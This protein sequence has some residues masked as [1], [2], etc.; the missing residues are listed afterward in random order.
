MATPSKVGPS[1]ASQTE[2]GPSASDPQGPE[3]GSSDSAAAAT[4]D[5]AAAAASAR[6]VAA[7]PPVGHVA[8]TEV[9]V[10]AMAADPDGRGGGVSKGKPRI[11]RLDEAVVNRIAAG[12]VVVRPSS[13]LKELLEN[14]L[15]AGSTSITV[16]A[17]SGGL[18]ALQIQDFGC[19][20]AVSCSYLYAFASF[21]LVSST[22]VGKPFTP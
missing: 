15:D 9:A 14:S 6:A 18:K 5:A 17:R 16:T 2:P 12:E 3:V 20:I 22:S 1:D 8:P 11:Q 13:A 10:A 7:S 19:G 21:Q 4:A